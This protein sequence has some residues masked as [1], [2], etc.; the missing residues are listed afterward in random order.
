VIIALS[1]LIGLV[2]SPI[3]GLMAF[4]ITYHE[5]LRHYPSKE[6]P[7]RIALEAALLT[8]A[9]FVIASIVIGFVLSRN[10]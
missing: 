2:I 5:Y 1:L 6:K 7:L 8:F 3:A 4:L 10:V 9:F